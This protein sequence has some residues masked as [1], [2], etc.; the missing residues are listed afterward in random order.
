MGSVTSAHAEVDLRAV[1]GRPGLLGAE[2]YWY[3]HKNGVGPGTSAGALEVG[4]SASQPDT[5]AGSSTV[6]AI[7]RRAQGGSPVTGR[8][9]VCL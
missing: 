7:V 2:E 6:A 9:H 8:H 5:P 4:G 1:K 3:D